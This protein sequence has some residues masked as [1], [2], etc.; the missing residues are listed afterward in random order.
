MPTIKPRL[1]TIVEEETYKKI[2]YLCA[3]DQRSESQLVKMIIQ[4][5]IQNYE[6][7]HGEILLQTD[8]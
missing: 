6:S 1:Q 3:K 7:E 4:E 8:K 2:K 5:Y